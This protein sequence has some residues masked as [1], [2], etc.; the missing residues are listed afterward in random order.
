[1]EQIKKEKLRLE[2]L[3]PTYIGGM[4]DK[5]LSNK[6]YYLENDIINIIGTSKL[7]KYLVENN[8]YEN[9]IKYINSS[10]KMNEILDIVIG[11]GNKEKV[12]KEKMKIES[13]VFERNE[14]K[15]NNID[16]FI[17]DSDN[18]PYIPA[19]TLKG[20]ITNAIG[21]N[22]IKNNEQKFKNCII[23]IKNKINEPRELK[24]IWNTIQSYIFKETYEDINNNMKWNLDL[25]TYISISDGIS[26]KNLKTIIAP[27]EDFSVN[28]KY[29][30]IKKLPIYREYICEE[31][32][33]DFEMIINYNK[34][35]KLG[36]N[37]IDDILNMLQNYT[38][39][40]F[41][42]DE[43][44]VQ[45]AN[46]QNICVYRSVEK[47]EPNV[48]LGG[49]AGY[50]SKSL[51]TALFSDSNELRNF[52]KRTLNKKHEHIK[53]D[54]ISSPRTLKLAKYNSNYYVVGMGRLYSI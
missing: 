38:D 43:K 10:K 8:K 46:M 47:N 7:M 21:F 27:K 30:K 17:K 11:E 39:A 32:I 33:F 20:F 36:V 5:N 45:R 18:R 25:R 13:K 35:K 15:L 52:V 50:Y 48:I 16:M 26:N 12:V 51:L 40:C 54:T 14:I 1:M 2:I 41:E 49:G 3:T 19:S 44:L 4:E 23:E 22:Y 28:V 42:M 31:A 37:S 53:K 9:F 34:L 29:E 24:K 6:D